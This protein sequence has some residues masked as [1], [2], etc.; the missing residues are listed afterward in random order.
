MEFLNKKY[1]FFAILLALIH[2]FKIPGIVEIE[3]LILTFLFLRK[4]NFNTLFVL[5]IILSSSL[6][7][8]LD[9]SFRFDSSNYPSIYT[10]SLYGIKYF[11]VLVFIIFI[12]SVKNIKFFK[13]VLLNKSL[14]F[15][16]WFIC[17]FSFIINLSGILAID[18]LLFN[19]RTQLLFLG[20]LFH[21]S[22]LSIP[23]VIT[24]AEYIIITW[25]IFMF[26]TIIFPHSSPIYRTIFNIKAI[27]YFAGEEYLTLGIY[28]TILLINSRINFN[29]KL[30]RKRL[31]YILF[32]GFC[33]CLISQRKGAVLYFLPILFFIYIKPFSLFFKSMIL[34]SLLFFNSIS[35]FIIFFIIFPFIENDI[36]LLL[37]D[38]GYNLFNSAVESVRY[39]FSKNPL[40]AIFGIGPYNKYELISLP[41]IYDHEYSFGSDMGM[42]FRYQIW[43]LPYGRLILNAGFIGVLFYFLYLIRI[44]IKKDILFLY[45]FLSLS[46]I[47]YWE[48]L[49]PVYSLP[50]ALA[51]V[52]LIKINQKTIK[53]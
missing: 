44:F 5:G 51:T 22:R 8:V 2:S 23:E 7:V 39:N 36:I 52:Y 46:P 20:L 12:S 29:Y 1:L 31:F 10:K 16:I 32:I 33:L 11:D 17:F 34:K 42:K 47:F 9:E 48:N 40:S 6:Y 49:A 26:F 45:L 14:P 37:L 21:F 53:I 27:I 50:F 19:I 28:A 4:V 41:G 30:N 3:F 25:V 15:L 43:Y 18:S 35:F 13:K 38:E 24:L